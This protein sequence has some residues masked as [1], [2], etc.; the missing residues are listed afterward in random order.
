MLTLS[1]HQ[2][3]ILVMVAEAGS[4]SRAAERL[5]LTQPT[6]SIQLR[7]LQEATGEQLLELEGR[8]LVLTDA[9]HEVLS[10][11]RAVQ[12]EFEHL[13]ER[14]AARRGIQQGTLNLAVVSTA[15]YFLPRVLGEFQQAHPG[16][17]VSL[18]VLNRAEVVARAAAHLDDAYLMTRPPEDA[19][20]R[21]EA[22]GSNPLV[23]IA[24]PDHPWRRRRRIPIRELVSSPFVAREVG[25][26]T[27][28]WADDWLR[29]RG[30]AV[31]TRL[32][33]GSNEA[34]KQAVRGGFG[35][36]ILSAHAVGLELEH[37]LLVLLSVS[38]FPLP[39]KWHFVSRAGRPLSPVAEAFRRFLK[40]EAMPALT[41]GLPA[42]RAGH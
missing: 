26:G 37:Q 11:A 15:E 27:R 18:K 7:Q 21:A 12:A 16:I 29:T 4:V 31:R 39:S 30:V 42:R 5:H 20:Y 36:A 9:G 38:G 3:R 17:D 28:L 41:R 14:L 23:V 10:T 40:R 13:R 25:S 19:A 32:E 1:L 22:V 33:L 35:L 8:R 6:L 2:L 34:V 24:A